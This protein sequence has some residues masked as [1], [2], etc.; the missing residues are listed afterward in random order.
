MTEHLTWCLPESSRLTRQRLL[1]LSLYMRKWVS[2]RPS[3]CLPLG[4]LVK[5]PCQSKV[6]LHGAETH[7]SGLLPAFQ[8]QC[9]SLV[10]QSHSCLGC[11][12]LSTGSGNASQSPKQPVQRLQA[13]WTWDRLLPTPHTP[14]SALSSAQG[15]P[16]VQLCGPH[17]RITSCC[18]TTQ[19]PSHLSHS[20]LC[21]KDLFHSQE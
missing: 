5:I 7:S 13:R 8:K 11:L 16:S 18:P 3:V 1:S 12:T 15:H 9:L 20:F 2:E 4:L 21:S 14:P 10:L 6:R 17:H 19:T